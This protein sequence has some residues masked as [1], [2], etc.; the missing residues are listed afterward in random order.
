MVPP[1]YRRTV[2]CLP[3]NLVLRQGRRPQFRPDLIVLCAV[4]LARTFFAIRQSVRRRQC[5][6]HNGNRACSWTR[7]KGQASGYDQG[8]CWSDSWSNWSNLWIQCVAW[9]CSTV[10]VGHCQLKQHHNTSWTSRNARLIYD[11]NEVLS[12]IPSRRDS[13][14]F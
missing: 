10:K 14:C 8:Y 6:S 13:T 9:T 5:P 2:P 1:L 4:R 7:W 11:G 12:N 3:A